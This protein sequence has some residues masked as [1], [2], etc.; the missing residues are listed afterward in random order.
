MSHIGMNAKEL[1]A[2]VCARGMTILMN[3][4][5]EGTQEE[6]D[7]NKGYNEAKKKIATKAQKEYKRAK[8]CSP[9]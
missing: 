3:P 2:S 7:F 4:F 9:N 6:K 1:G 5:K 8:R